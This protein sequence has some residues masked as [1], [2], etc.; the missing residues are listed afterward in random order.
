M[1]VGESSRRLLSYFPAGSAINQRHRLVM[2]R[3]TTCLVLAFTVLPAQGQ[4]TAQRLSSWLLQNDSAA[5]AYLSGL[6]WRVPEEIPAQL[7]LK[8]ELLRS[9]SE[10]S[11]PGRDPRHNQFLADL[12][13]AMPVTG[14]VPVAMV[15]ARW[16]QVHPERDPVLLPGHQIDLPARPT[17]VTVIA[18]GVALCR[19]KHVAGQE[20]AAYVHACAASGAT[21]DWAWVAQP[22][23]RIDR[24]GI[25][26]WN[27]EQ[28][29]L[30]A[31]GAWIWAPPANAGWTHGFSQKLITFLSYQ[32]PA[33]DSGITA[34]KTA[35]SHTS[36]AVS[37]GTSGGL[38]WSAVADSHINPQPPANAPA[39]QQE[40]LPRI[41]GS[42][43]RSRGMPVTASDWGSVGLMQM[44]SARMRDVGSLAVTV[45]R[46][47]PYTTMNVFLQP[48]SWMEAGFRYTSISNRIYGPANLA[49]DQTYKDKAFDVKFTLWDESAT[50]PA[51]GMGFRDLAGTGFFSGEYLV[52]TKRFNDLDVSLGLGWGNYA[53]VTRQ[54][55]V[56]SQG[57][58]FTFGNY[59]S[60]ASRP[61]GGVQW[62]V[63]SSPM[64][65]KVEYDSND[66]Q[67]E[68][69]GNRFE[70]KSKINFGLTYRLY[71]WLDLSAG[72]ERGNTLSIGLALHTDLS[73]LSVPKLADAP[74]VPVSAER[75][76]TPPDWNRT[77][78]DLTRQTDWKVSQITVDGPRVT[79]TMDDPRGVHWQD[80][81]DRAASVLHRDAPA[82]VDRFVLRYQSRGMG[83]SEQVID[84]QAWVGPQLQPV[85]PALQGSAVL[86][87]SPSPEPEGTTPFQARPSP[88]DSNFRIG[89]SQSFGGP[90]SFVLYQIYAEE[91]V[92]LT[93][94]RPDTWLT[95]AA[96]LRLF[97]NYDKFNYTAPSNLPRVRT[98]LR[99]YLTTSEL[100]LSNLQVTHARK[101]SENHYASIY[102]GYLEEMFA[103]F[104][105]EWLY[106]PFASRFAFGIDANYVQQRDFHQ[107]LS[108]L[109]P[110]YR[111]GTGHATAYWDT[112]WNQVEV[113]GSAGRYLAGDIGITAE[114]SRRFTNGVMFGAYATKTN[115]SAQ[116][117]GEGSFDKGVFLSIPF[118]AMFT[119]SSSK[120]ANFEWKPLTRDGGAML[121]RS[122]RLYNITRTRD[123]RTFEYK[124]AP[125]P[126]AERMPAD[127]SPMWQPASAAPGPYMSVAEKQD[128]KQP[129]NIEEMRYRI[130]QALDRQGFRNVSVEFD[131]SHRLNLKVAHDTMVP[132]SRAVGRAARTALSLAPEEARELRIQFAERV[133]PVV[134]YDFL[135]LKRL[136]KYMSGELPTAALQNSVSVRYINPGA[137]E[138]DPLSAIAD[139]S[140]VVQSPAITDLKS[141][142]HYPARVASDIESAVT[143]AAKTDWL[144]FTGMGLAA[145][146]G[147][148]VLDSKGLSFAKTHANA[149]WLKAVNRVG[150]AIP[151]LGFAG[152]G[153]LA[154]DGSD[155]RRSRT[156]YAAVEAGAAS[157]LVATGLKYVIGR[158]RPNSTSSRWDLHPFE[159]EP[160]DSMPSRH[161][162]MAWAIATPFALE[163]RAPWLYGVAAL[164]NLS[165]VGKQ[166]HWFSDTVAGSV[167]G[168]GLGRLFWESSRGN[169][170]LPQVF[171]DPYGINFSWIY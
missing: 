8:L 75:P 49:Q 66:Y 26:T 4:Q 161:T 107:N 42:Q 115:V 114:V 51:I 72:Y 170:S 142:G 6:S 89:Y 168:Y 122:E 35:P 158:P 57:G 141:L 54:R 71:P 70:Q 118:D 113:R 87:R 99:E 9:I 98:Y 77:A 45:N 60:G 102:G 145:V 30:P 37:G 34:A 27:R 146:A 41:T 171:V 134:E 73:K 94:G 29:G 36:P 69:L 155:P 147:S 127:H 110:S 19:V 166:A 18:G 74:R 61:F 123:L 84:R 38:R 117:F 108:M 11:G 149:S 10:A 129:K 79:V 24:Y 50:L 28:Q 90:D 106:R 164:T 14:R 153:L 140:V 76:A 120:I 121:W 97:D 48:L 13:A 100:T 3:C 126:N 151:L 160:Y 44:P 130:V 22:D 83:L 91:S 7:S 5:T 103:G 156:G 138:V 150:D 133:D 144:Q 53:G 124:A 25:G 85:P 154:L 116:E 112:G 58:D 16:L 88:W 12:I 163:Y 40:Q 82:E 1:S 21:A 20:A 59:F 65:L 148:S 95:G 67:N 64:L 101:L 92:R 119:K 81:V 157:V 125:P 52:S 80:R 131:Q 143:V 165:R 31:P 43:G 68:P 162:A 139:T 104:G 2:C 17:T 46:V 56:G 136:E 135:D 39:E 33:P 32:G 93:L 78:E 109:N 15:D 159:G 132:P 23:G 47:E 111:V 169:S 152:A 96:R 137:R 63:P 86:A 167:V 128:L 105:G 55:A 62:H